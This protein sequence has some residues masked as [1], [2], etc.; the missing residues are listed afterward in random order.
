[1][2]FP[3]FVRGYFQKGKK[4]MKKRKR[5]DSYPV[6][7]FTIFDVANML[8]MEFLENCKNGYQVKDVQNAANVVCPFCGDARGK[9]SICVCAEGKIINVFHCFDCGTGHNML[10]LYA[11]LCHLTGKDRYKKAYREI[12]RRKQEE[13]GRKKKTREAMQEE[14]QGIKKQARKQKE[15]MAEPVDAEQ[16]HHVYKKMLS[17]LKLKE[18]HR[19]DLERRGVNAE[20]IRC[21]EEKG[22]KSTSKEESQ[23]IARRLIKQGLRLE[24]VPGF[25]IN[26]E[27]D[28]DLNFYEGNSGYLCPVYT[29]D[30][31]LAGFQIRLDNPKGKNKYV[32]L[33]SA[34]Q[35]KGCGI[36]SIVGI[37]GK[38]EGNEIYVTEGILKAEIAHQVSG[39]TFLG[40]PGIGNWRD[41]YEVL[42]ALKKRG[43]SHVEEV[44]DMDKQLRLI[45]DKKYSEICEECEERK[46]EGDP[47]FECPKK[48][49][50][51]DTIRKGCNHTYRICEELS[52]SCNRNQWDLDQDGLWAEHEKGIDDW[53]TKEIRENTR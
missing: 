44:Y 19:K 26:R 8:D 7:P 51:R 42:Q 12:Y 28:W 16:R 31:Y 29:V 52:L 53:L 41:L 49:V 18:Y 15:R 10:T 3:T 35:K 20:I 32:W 38:A 33:S 50:K 34:N 5:T 40:N 4:D 23:Q 25:Y 6:A 13:P 45:C 1:M 14:S 48:R 47:Y 21:M 17:Y 30:G 11:E 22:Y 9:A 43:L 39:K 36:S 24:G 46:K 2:P 27:G 37:S